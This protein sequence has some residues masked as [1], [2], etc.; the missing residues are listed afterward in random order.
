MSDDN[1]GAASE[2]AP[3]GG[4]PKKGGRYVTIRRAGARC[5]TRQCPIPEDQVGKDVRCPAFQG[6]GQLNVDVSCYV[7]G[8]VF[9]YKFVHT[10]LVEDE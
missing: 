7:C 3:S 4:R 5:D 9:P 1:A 2:A 8:F 6:W 10:E